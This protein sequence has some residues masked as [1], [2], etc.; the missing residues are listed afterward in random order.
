MLL[1]TAALDPCNLLGLCFESGLRAIV[2]FIFSK[3]VDTSLHEIFLLLLSAR[4]RLGDYL[5]LAMGTEDGSVPLRIR[6]HTLDTATVRLDAGTLLAIH[7]R[8]P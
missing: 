6:G 1:D 3:S 4:K 7:T 2:Q 8:T 5:F